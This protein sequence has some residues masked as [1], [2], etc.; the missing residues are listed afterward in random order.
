MRRTLINI[1]LKD[2]AIENFLAL[3]QK[4]L[5][6]PGKIADWNSVHAPGENKLLQYESLPVPSGINLSR[7]AVCKLNGGLGTSMGCKGPKS[8]IHV[9]DGK[10]FLDLIVDHLIHIREK[11][12]VE[13]PLLLMN[14]FYTHE[15]TLEIIG[16]F[17]N[18]YDIRSFCQNHFPRIR[19]ENNEP[20]GT[21]FGM[22]AWY[23]PGHGDF[24]SCVYEQGILDALIADGKE[25][26]F[27]SN[28]D[29]LGAGIDLRILNYMVE[30]RS[31]FLIEM[32]PKTPADVKGGTLYL[33][34]GK[35]KLLEIARVPDEHVEEFCSQEKFK[36]FNT[37]NI[38]INLA[39]LRD[40]LRQGP[41]DLQVIVNRKQVGEIPVVQ[42]ETAVGS[43]L[44]C[45]AGAVGLTVS[46]NRFLPVKTTND[47][48]LIQSDQFVYIDGLLRRNPE[49]AE[50]GLPSIHLGEEFSRV[51]DYTCKIPVIP[52]MLELESLELD[53]DV[54][55]EGEA[56]LKGKVR[57]VAQNQPLVIPAGAVLENQIV[58]Q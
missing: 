12:K 58:E 43:A 11:F 48:L 30:S 13:V 1:G 6:G 34:D 44:E 8:A 19:E 2:K 37:N 57:L 9:R 24:Y 51:E 32:T 4:Y 18:S 56:T 49:R 5:S 33:E 36:V 25:I 52:H 39:L 22:D 29:N 28:A 42:L 20:L 16:K 46:R 55:F 38:W 17:T 45:F 26:L 14:S 23:P 7:L 31:P 3:Y 54:R 53:G 27:I 50:S 40:K 15:E 10:S 21:D 41:L 47:L 35:L